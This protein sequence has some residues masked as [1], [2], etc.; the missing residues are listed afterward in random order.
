MNT[1]TDTSAAAL[2]AELQK[3]DQI[4]NPGMPDHLAKATFDQSGSATSGLT[5]YDLEPGAKFLYP[6]L[7]PMRNMVPRVSGRGGI[8]ANWRAITGI[9]TTNIEIGVSEGNRGAVMAVST[10]DYLAAYKGIGLESSL[11]FEAQYAAQNFA[12]IRAIAGKTGLQATMLREERLILAGNGSLA[13][14]V[15]PTPT[16]VGSTTGGSLAAQTWSVIC[17]ALTHAGLVSATV[18]G[19]IPTLITRTNADGSTDT[20]GGGSAQRS[21]AATAVT[22]GAT[23]SITARVAAVRGALGYAWFWGVGGT[24]LLGA[25]TTIPTHVIT[26]TAAGTQN[27]S[28]ASADR[29]VNNLIFDGFLTQALRPG[30]NAYWADLG[31]TTLTADGS[32]GIVEIDALLSNRWDTYRL[33]PDTI[34]CSAVDA[35]NI[36]RKILQGN[37]NGALRFNV[38]LDQSAMQG[39]IMV[40]TYLNSFGMDGAKVLNIKIHPNMP[41]GTLLFMTSTMP[42]PMSDV[43]NMFQM[44][45]RQDYYQIEWPLTTRRYQYGVY[46]DEVL[47]HY[48]PPSMGVITGVHAG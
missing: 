22:T 44:L 14:G 21:T 1:Q 6:V 18:G 17:V 32:G 10:E 35:K 45:C 2:M 20:Y 39:G 29:S 41:Q 12:D 7:T 38:N 24:E 28:V 46:A 5:Y 43:T 19:G 9:N 31:G 40:S 30:S 42:Y 26:A 27:A 25:I 16:L 23:S 11:S 13:L 3:M 8:Q 4:P 48:F 34:W 15:T 47:Q 33:S 36:G 37:A